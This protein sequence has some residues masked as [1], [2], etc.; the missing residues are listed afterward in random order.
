MKKEGSKLFEL[1]SPIDKTTMK[2]SKLFELYLQVAEKI[3]KESKFLK[4]FY[5]RINNSKA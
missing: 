5:I 1:C 2:G 4:P 3:M